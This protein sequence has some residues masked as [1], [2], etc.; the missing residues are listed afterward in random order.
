MRIPF[1][2]L[3]LS[4]ACGGA[5]YAFGGPTLTL[6]MAVSG[7]SAI[8]AFYL[9][10]KACL[11]GRK[12]APAPVQ[13]A[14]TIAR[15]RVAQ[16][17]TPEAQIPAPAR[18]K[19][20][21]PS[22]RGA[23]WR[24]SPPRHVVIDGSN[25]MHW[26]GEV[27]RLTTLKEVVAALIGQGYQ[28]GI[29]FDANAGYKLGDRYLD[30]RDFAKLLNLP[31]DRV[32]V[33]GKGEPAD[34]TILAAA[35]DLGAKVVTNDRFRDWATDFPEVAEN[36]FLVHGGYRDGKLWLEERVLTQADAVAA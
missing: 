29:V 19:G 32:L 25:V 27:P 16:T 33:V 18:K 1:V 24:R 26:N 22:R 31:G 10:I 5:S 20:P 36:N 13:E 8:A 2:L 11:W 30:D 12:K 28:P 23:I 3:L 34:P 15:V 7:L 17:P 6:P 35:R 4:L 9:V 14:Q 21:R